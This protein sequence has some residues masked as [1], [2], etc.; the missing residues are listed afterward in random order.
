MS[1]DQE[2]M[3]ELRTL[4][5][6]GVDRFKKDGQLDLRYVTGIV[7]PKLKEVVGDIGGEI[8]QRHMIDRDENGESIFVT[9]YTGIGKLFSMLQGAAKG[10]ETSL[11]L[12]D[13]V[14]FNDPDEGYYFLRNL[15][16]GHDWLK[17]DRGYSSHAYIVSF[18]APSANPEKNSHDDLVFWRTYGREGEGC[19]LRVSVPKSRLRKVSYDAEEARIAAK[20]LLPVLNAVK[21]LASVDSE[22]RDTLARAFWESLKG[23]Q[24]L[25]KS[26]AYDYENELRFIVTES[27][28][29]ENDLCFEYRDTS[30][31]SIRHYCEDEELAIKKAFISD[32]MITIG[33][34]VLN[35]DDLSHVLG[36][37]TR[38][39]KLYG[40]RIFPS[41]IPYR[42]S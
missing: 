28:V 35:Y 4:V 37:L 13:S 1:T 36:I 29:D 41:R 2:G 16:T 11:R 21:P 33:P 5:R 27:D 15:L 18:V 42:K 20:E 40:V 14:H 17:V 22:I 10:E 34:C 31:V 7:V 38:R 39:A 8:S 9:H 30:P 32:S 19:S 3:R 26:E 23:I 12:Y 24:F 25:Y 6:G